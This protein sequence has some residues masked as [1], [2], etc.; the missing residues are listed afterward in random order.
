MDDHYLTKPEELLRGPVGD[1][2]LDLENPLVLE[3]CT[4]D[5]EERKL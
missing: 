2:I 3:V 4:R 5:Y 1:I